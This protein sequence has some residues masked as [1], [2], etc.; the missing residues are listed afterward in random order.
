M[1]FLATLACVTQSYTPFVPVS[2]R[3]IVMTGMNSAGVDLISCVIF[4]ISNLATID[5]LFPY[6]S[7][8]TL[9]VNIY[10]CWISR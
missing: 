7:E 6:L 8:G 2:E 5:L 9:C 1:F 4:L 3:Q 10:T